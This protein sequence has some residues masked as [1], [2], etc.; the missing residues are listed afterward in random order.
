[1][2]KIINFIKVGLYLI[3]FYASLAVDL[4]KELRQ[5]S[6]M[7]QI[8]F[9]TTIFLIITLISKEII[10]LNEEVLVVI[11]FFSFIFFLQ[12][13]ISDMIYLE[14]VSRNEKIYREADLNLFYHQE[15]INIILD[16][17]KTASYVQNKLKNEYVFFR[18]VFL[19]NLWPCKA[20]DYVNNN[21]KHIEKNFNIIYTEQKNIYQ[22][23][24]VEQNVYNYELLKNLSKVYMG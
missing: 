14:L 22:N 13:K 15:I 9:V 5:M 17:Y 8:A 4:F 23:I 1:M 18:H 16:L 2:N 7:N 10:V 12:S 20:I 6:G 19:K 21:L 11:S 24:Q 3:T